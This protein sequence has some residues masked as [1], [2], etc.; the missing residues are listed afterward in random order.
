M[1]QVKNELEQASND[2]G[3]DTL[4]P[5]FHIARSVKEL[6]QTGKA[7]KDEDKEDTSWNQWFFSDFV[8]GLFLPKELVQVCFQSTSEIDTE[9]QGGV[10]LV[11][12][13]HVDSLPRD[14]DSFGKF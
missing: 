11:V 12:F 5:D 8:H 6:I 4:Q 10:V 1:I 13:N 14:P 2:A 3:N 7:E 9:F